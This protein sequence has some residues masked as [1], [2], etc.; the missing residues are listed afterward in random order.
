MVLQKNPTTKQRTEKYPLQVWKTR[1]LQR[2]CSI[3]EKC[4]AQWATYGDQ[5][6]RTTPGFFCKNCF[7][8]AHYSSTTEA[9]LFD[10]RCFPYYHDELQ[11]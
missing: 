4:S 9:P 8:S 7:S 6:S 10:F 11:G 1:V 5:M 3:C 2:K